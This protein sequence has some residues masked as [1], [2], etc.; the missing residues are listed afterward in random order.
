[1]NR[2]HYSRQIFEQTPN[3]KFNLNLFSSFSRIKLANRQTCPLRYPFIL[4]ISCED[5]TRIHYCE[6]LHQDFINFSRTI[7]LLFDKNIFSALQTLQFCMGVG[8][9]HGNLWLW[10][11]GSL[12][13]RPTPTWKTRLQYVWPLTFYLSG[14]GGSSRNLRSRQHNPPLQDKAVVLEEVRI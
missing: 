4:H 11:V 14:M 6:I 1:M 5:G 8:L 2:N 3:I 13:P 7:S 10:R 12:S 9:L